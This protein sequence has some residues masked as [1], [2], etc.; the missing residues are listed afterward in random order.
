MS[1]PAA[2]LSRP[3]ELEVS[4]I[5][6]SYVLKMPIGAFEDVARHEPKIQALARRLGDGTWSLRDIAVVIDAAC[7]ASGVALRFREIFQYEGARAVEV[8]GWL[9]T[10]GLTHEDMRPKVRAEAENALGLESE[11]TSDAAP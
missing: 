5:G 10:V 8:A 3:G 4:L 9:L 1:E 11:T 7:K 2:E 6:H